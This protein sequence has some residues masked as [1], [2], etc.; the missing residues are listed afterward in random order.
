MGK[1][2]LGLNSVMLFVRMVQITDLYG[3]YN[4]F[5]SIGRLGGTVEESMRRYFDKDLARI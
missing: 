4:S 2:R 1:D 3:T 5:D